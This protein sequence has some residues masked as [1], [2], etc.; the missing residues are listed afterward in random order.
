MT[1]N[2]RRTF[3]VAFGGVLVAS[4]M[5]MYQHAHFYHVTNEYFVLKK[6]HI[7]WFRNTGPS[8]YRTFRSDS[9]TFFS[10]LRTFGLKILRTHE[11][12]NLRTF[13]LIGCNRSVC[14]FF[15]ASRSSQ[16]GKKYKVSNWNNTII[17]TPSVQIIYSSRNSVDVWHFSIT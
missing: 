15:T 5:Y 6:L 7:S 9:R 8:D 4:R 16:N 2:Q 11:P 1:L 3:F 13:G 17:I 10:N 14:S 12:S